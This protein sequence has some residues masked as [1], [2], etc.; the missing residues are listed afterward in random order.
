ML[1]G[2]PV[3]DE[4]VEVQQLGPGPF[5]LGQACGQRPSGLKHEDAAIIVIVLLGHAT[6][7]RRARSLTASR[8]AMGPFWPPEESQ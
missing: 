3:G 2:L 4:G 6:G 8:C 7:C 5:A 1:Q